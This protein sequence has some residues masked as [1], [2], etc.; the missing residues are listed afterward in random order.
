MIREKIQN[1]VKEAMRAK[2]ELK[3]STLRLLIGAIQNYEIAKEGTSYEADDEEI[4]EVIGKEVKKRKESIEQFK[5][6][7]RNELVEKETKEMGILQEYLPEQMGEDEIKKIVDEK[8]KEVGASS[9]TDIGKVMG[10]LSGEL[11]GKADMGIVSK[12]VKES[13]S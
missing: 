5:A 12:L 3:V 11:K 10:A 6:G 13:L 9:I 7:G 4:K 8:I 1:D 2:E